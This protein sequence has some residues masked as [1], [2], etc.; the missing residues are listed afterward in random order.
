VLKTHFTKPFKEYSVILSV[1]NEF[2]KDRRLYKIIFVVTSPPKIIKM[3]F[4]TPARQSITQKI[5]I[6]IAPC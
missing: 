3:N 5:P 1:K 2:L 6:K 4:K